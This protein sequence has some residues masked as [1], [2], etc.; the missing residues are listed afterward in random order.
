MVFSAMAETLDFHH[1]KLGRK[2]SQESVS[3]AFV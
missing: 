1:W 3:S 2:V